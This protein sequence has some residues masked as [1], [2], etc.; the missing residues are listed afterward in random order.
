[1]QQF[2]TPGAVRVEIRNPAG[3][4]RLE[5][6]EG[7][8]TAVELSPLSQGAEELIERTRVEAPERGGRHEVLI[9]VPRGHSRQPEVGVAITV[10]AGAEVT[11]QVASADVTLRGRLGSL[12][13]RGAS[14]DVEV[15]EVTGNARVELASGDV[16]IGSVAGDLRSVTASGDL[17]AG[18]VGG[19]AELESASGDV[20]VAELD[21]GARLR[22]ASGD[23][24][25]EAAGAGINAQST[26]GDVVVATVREGTFEVRSTSGDV[27]IGVATGSRVDVEADSRSGR[28]SSEI[29]LDQGSSGGGEG[30]LV[31]IRA[32]T[33]SGDVRIRRATEVLAR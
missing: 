7:G 8:T 30:P 4:V 15:D 33:L 25:V 21:Q 26:S 31:T 27:E 9:D 10:P 23:V 14:G 28:C 6:V 13:V 29:P 19:R 17:R 11:V 22:T 32:R 24:R 18:R 20:T 3:W 5:A 1:M 2:E 12:D 16:R